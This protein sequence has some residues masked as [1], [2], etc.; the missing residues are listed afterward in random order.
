MK[1]LIINITV[2]SI[3]A[4]LPTFIFAQDLPSSANLIVSRGKGVGNITLGMTKSE[5]E[6]IL[7]KGV[8]N[9]GARLD[10]W[11]LGISV[12]YDKTTTIITNITVLF[13]GYDKFKDFKGK[14]EGDVKTLPQ[15]LAK[16]GQPLDSETRNLTNETANYVKFDGITFWLSDGKITDVAVTQMANIDLQ[17]P[18]PFSGTKKTIADIDCKYLLAFENCRDILFA[19]NR[20]DL[21]QQFGMYED[22]Q[23]L[24]F[25]EI[26]FSNIGLINSLTFSEGTLGFKPA[27]G[28]S[29]NEDLKNVTKILGEPEKLSKI[30]NSNGVKSEVAKYSDKTLIF[31]KGKLK[32]IVFTRPENKMESDV[33][34]YE[35][36]KNANLNQTPETKAKNTASQMETDYYVL[37]DQLDAKIREGE[38]IVN[39]EKLAIAAGGMFKKA[40][41]EKLD[42]VRESGISLVDSFSKKYQGNIPS[43]MVKGILDKWKNG[44]AIN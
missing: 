5:V 2:F 3:L 22:Y 28:I 12:Y 11:E 25:A 37:L 23:R 24:G 6:A 32:Y 16:Y 4:I 42:K 27:D 21:L 9:S 17:R 41:E 43:W 14:I 8:D 34:K 44:A 36:E 1:Q 40:V 13:K 15:I 30:K 31:E 10:Y 20:Q 26:N 7:G 39:S 18:N 38:R 19:T 35:R 33:A 29:W